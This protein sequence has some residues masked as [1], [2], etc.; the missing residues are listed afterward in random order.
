MDRISGL[1]PYDFMVKYTPQEA[2]VKGKGVFLWLAFF[3]SEIGAG[4][5]LVSLFVNLRVGYLTGWLITLILG[6]GFHL[7]FLGRPTRA[8]LMF[9]N[10]GKS[11]LSRGL[12]VILFFAVLGFFQI[13]PAVVPGLPWSG[14]GFALKVIMGVIS[15]LLITHGFL[16]MSMVRAIPVWNSAMMV[17]LSVVSGLWVGS[18][19]AVLISLLVGGEMGIAETWARGCLF[20]FIVFLGVYLLGAAQSSAAAQVS[21]KRLLGGEWS[22]PF[23]IGVVLIG[24]V[25]PVV[26]TVVI[27][28]DDVN[29][30]SVGFLWLRCL[31]VFVGDLMMRYGIMRNAYYSPLI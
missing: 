1:M 28:G 11:E 24:M 3:F 31:C 12:W 22:G 17:P 9:L 4:I 19:V 13:A 26:I 23:Y 14:S 16:T 2:W 29:Q 15:V 27:W 20:A 6:G 21:V 5:Y 30:V 8:L 7:L 10:P 25:V 18:Q